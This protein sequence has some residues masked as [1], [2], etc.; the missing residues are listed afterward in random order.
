MRTTLS[1]A[2]RSFVVAGPEAQR[3]LGF[4]ALSTLYAGMQRGTIPP[5]AAWGRWKVAD[6]DA[7]LDAQRA[8]IEHQRATLRRLV[9]A[10]HER[11]R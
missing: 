7:V 6:I 10:H 5:P 11:M 3:A 9:A 4:K 2:D 1:P 8:A